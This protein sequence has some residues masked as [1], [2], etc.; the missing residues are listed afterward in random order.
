MGCLCRAAS[1][2][3]SDPSDFSKSRGPGCQAELRK[4]HPRARVGQSGWTATDGGWNVLVSSQRSPPHC[5]GVMLPSPH[6]QVTEEVHRLLRRCPYHFVCRGKVSVK[7]K[8]EMLTYFL[9]GRTDGN[10]SQI[11]SLGLDRK[12]GPYGRA[13]LQGRRPP[14]C[15]MPGVSVRAGLP[16]HSPGQ[17]LS[18]AAAGKEA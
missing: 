14:V 13:G 18:S 11:R 9:E 8:G 7:G 17:Y 10:G 6:Q 12:M 2:L 5:P 1:F 3:H 16:A 15:P 4:P